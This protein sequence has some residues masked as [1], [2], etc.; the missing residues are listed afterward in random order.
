[1]EIKGLTDFQKDLLN[2]SKNIDKEI[3]KILRKVGSKARTVVARRA[4]RDVKKVTG[5]YHKSWKRG[6]TFRGN[7]GAWTVR[8][9]NSAPHAHLIEDGHRMVDSEGNDLGKFV[10]GKNVL[11]TG[12]KEFD[13]S[14]VADEM[15]E[16]W[17]DD[18][19]EQN[20]L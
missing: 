15:F 8:V 9:Y 13:D 14:K 20:K 6:K 4:R 11:N 5:N 19:L 2:S 16:E 12:M 1:M 18:L 7:D 3:P 10:Q 17:L